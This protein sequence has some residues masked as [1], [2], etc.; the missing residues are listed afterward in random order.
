MQFSLRTG[1]I[2]PDNMHMPQWMRPVARLEKMVYRHRKYVVAFH[3][4]PLTL[5]RI[6]KQLG[7]LLRCF[8][9]ADDCLRYLSKCCCDLLIIDLE[10]AAEEALDMLRKVRDVCPWPARLVLVAGDDTAGAVEAMKA[11]ATECLT[12]PLQ[13]EI[14]LSVVQR[15]LKRMESSKVNSPAVLTPMELKILNMVLAGRTS[16]EM[17]GVLNRSKRTIDAHR[18]R[19]MHKLGASNLLD[20]ARWAISRGFGSSRPG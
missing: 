14:L 12:K 9:Q 3:V 7:V 16:K 6:A 19:I 5:E 13:E 1:N 20:L 15:E 18:S 10:P 8:E 17:A 2:P 4:Q 11:G